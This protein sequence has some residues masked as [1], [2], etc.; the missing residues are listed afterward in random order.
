MTLTRRRIL[1]ITAGTAVSVF[2]GTSR[3]REHEWR[4]I[5]LG[6]EVR[7]ILH[8][9]DSV[10]SEVL[11]DKV[12]QE[13]DRLE[14]IFSLYRPRSTLSQLNDRGVVANPPSD[15]LKV[16][17]LATS[18]H[19][20]TQGRFDPTIQPVWAVYATHRGRPPAAALDEAAQIIGWNAVRFNSTEVRFER[21]GMA[22]TLNGIA[23]GYI[24]DAIV[25]LLRKEGIGNAVVS[26]GETATLGNR[27]GIEPWRI[28]IATRENGTPE[29]FIRLSDRAI[30]TSA[31]TGMTIGSDGP[32]HIINPGTGRSCKSQWT[33]VSV[34]HKSAAL[35]DAL[36]TA[37]VLMPA[38]EIEQSIELFDGTSVLALDNNGRSFRA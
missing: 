33:R 35:A 32:S 16:L 15:F 13:I 22:V 14:N 4:S 27:D 19:A 31:A 5:A 17:S 18:V 24:T 30:A 20:A 21:P 36:S 37:Y 28:G 3:A 8:G 7:L 34:L 12:R 6:A 11:F 2:M 26:A 25:K 29:E 9:L 10:G 1:T 23:Q 38:N